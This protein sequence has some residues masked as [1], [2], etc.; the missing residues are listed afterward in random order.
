MPIIVNTF[1]TAAANGTAVAAAGSGVGAAGTP[2]DA[3]TTGAGTSI[4]HSTAHP[5]HGSL[6]A[7]ITIGASAAQPAYWEWSTALT[8]S[9]TSSVLYARI[10]IYATAIVASGELAILRGLATTNQRWRV[11][12]TSAG[13]IAVY[14][15][16]VTA[17]ATSSTTIATNTHYRVEVAAAASATQPSTSIEV[18]VYADDAQ[19]PLETLGPFTNVLMG[20]PVDRIRFGVGAS[21]SPSSTATLYIDDLGASTV[22]WL[23]PAVAVPSVTHCW[24]G[25]ITHNQVTV[26]YGLANIASARLAVSTSVGMGSPVYSSAVAPDASGVVKLTRA[27]LSAD[28]TYYYGIEA[29]GTLIADGRGS[30][31][32]DPTPGTTGSFSIAF[33]SCQQTGSNAETFQVIA[34]RVG[35]YGKARRFIHEGDIHYRDFGA[36]TQAADVVGQWKSSLGTP[37]MRTLL[38]TIPTTYSWDNHD[39]AGPDSNATAPAGPLLAAA[40]RQFVPHYPLAT[41][42]TTAIHQSFV[43]NRVRVIILDTRS[44]RSDRTLAESSSKTMLGAEQKTWLKSELLQPEPLK[45]LVSGI[46][47]RRDAT[48]GDRWGSYQTEWAEIRDWAAANAGGIGKVLVISGDRHALY[49]DDGSGAAG[50]GGTYWPN[51]SGA[52]FDQ[53]SSQDFEPWSHGYYYVTGNLK[54]FGWLDITDSGA[55]ITV[56]YSGITALDAVT[57]VSMTVEV[58]AAAALPARFGIHL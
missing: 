28:T 9:T 2:A 39:W 25:A 15:S 10:G 4:V 58:P 44:Q 40:Y 29:D 27:S 42:G 22:T 18:R 3:V 14:G 16:D 26:S 49:A 50:T 38:S 1:E 43:I 32:T 24:A 53:G 7:L 6:G 19:T 17:T 11:A 54:A 48:N 12:L 56:A 8:A 41:A 46:Y 35:P 55:G 37:R 57:R 36:G 51:V 52:A 33:G 30:V 47:W 5:A 13:K 20:G 34:E 23:G 31:T 45:I 21:A